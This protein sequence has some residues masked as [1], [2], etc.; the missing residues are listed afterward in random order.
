M[1][2]IAQFKADEAALDKI[3]GGFTIKDTAAHVNADLIAVKKDASHSTN[4][5]DGR[6]LRRA[7]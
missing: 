5:R 4:R 6:R 3:A 2:T 7:V 1:V